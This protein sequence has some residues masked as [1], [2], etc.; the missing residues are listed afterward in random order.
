MH[1]F[2]S[3]KT[4]MQGFLGGRTRGVSSRKRKASGLGWPVQQQAK[5]RRTSATSCSQSATIYYDFTQDC[6]L[7]TIPTLARS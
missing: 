5:R 6:L 4:T 3:L 1:H 7:L 2:A